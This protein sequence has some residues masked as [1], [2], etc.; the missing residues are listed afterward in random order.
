[1]LTRLGTSAPRARPLP[2][3][4]LRP[5]SFLQQA[6]QLLQLGEHEEALAMA[7]LAGPG[8]AAQR[9]QLEDSTHLAFG[10]RL[11]RW[12]G[13]MRRACTFSCRPR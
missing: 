2:T 3:L 4:Q 13:V 8:Q 9:R 12:A 5:V 10:Q 11:F 6:Q 7:A 1:M